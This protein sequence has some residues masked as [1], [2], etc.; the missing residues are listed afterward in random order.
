MFSIMWMSTKEMFLL[1]FVLIWEIEIK[2]L[3]GKS[4]LRI[5]ALTDEFC[6]LKVLFLKLSRSHEYSSVC[7]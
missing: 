5:P 7:V 2:R 6:F 4:E 1:Y 3:K